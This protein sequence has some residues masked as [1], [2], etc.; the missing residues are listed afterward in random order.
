MK[1]GRFKQRTSPMATNPYKSP[2]DINYDRS[3]IEGEGCPILEDNPPLTDDPPLIEKG[4]LSES[5]S[6]SSEDNLPPEP[7]ENVEK[8]IAEKPIAE[9]KKQPIKKKGGPKNKK[10]QKE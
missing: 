5:R 7:P 1:T 9:E 4:S 2:M 10:T 3:L 6:F 8:K